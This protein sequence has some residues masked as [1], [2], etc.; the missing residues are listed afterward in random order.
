[1]NIQSL[2][3]LLAAILI[4]V[5]GWSV[6]L[7]DR[8][9]RQ[10]VTFT[11]LCFN[12]CFWYL[13]RFFVTTITSDVL[14]WAG[15]LFA[16]AIPTSAERFFRAFLAD[17]P[18]RPHPMSRPVIVSTTIFYL[19]LFVSLFYPVYRSRFFTLPLLFF[20]F[21]SLYHCVYLIYQRQRSIASRPEATRLTYLLYGGATTI[22]LAALDFVPHASLIF[23]TLGNVLTVVFM[24]FLSQTLFHYRLLDIKELLGKMVTLS[25]L[26]LILTVIYGLLLAWVGRDQPGVFFF[27]TVVASFVILVL[28]EQLRTRVEDRVNRWL[29]AEKYAFS[30]RLRVLTQDLANIIEARLAAARILAELEHS[31]RV[32]HVSI[33]L[34]D[35]AGASYRLAG[36]VGPQPVDVLDGT[37]RRLFL[38]RLR[39]SGLV[40]IEGLER[41]L[42]VQTAEN[43]EDAVVAVR[44]LLATMEDLF[45][46]VC[47]PLVSDKQ[48]LGILCLRDD[49]LREAYGTDELE[50]LR[51]VAA[52]AAITLRN[53]QVYEQM[54]ER[55]RLAALGQMAA[56]LAHEIRNPLGAI[57]GAA[58]LLK[59]DAP[60]DGQS[61]EKSAELGEYVEIIVEE[62]NRLDRVVSQ[63]LGYA[64]PDRGERQPLAINDVVFKTVQLLRSQAG[65]VE[66]Q[67]ELA[68]ELPEVRADPEQLRQVFLNLGINGIQAMD[69]KGTLRVETRLRRG[70]KRGAA[71][72]FVEVIFKDQGV[73]IPPETLSDIFIPFYTTKDGGTGLGLPICQRIVENH[74][75]T[76]EVRSEPGRGSSFT[77]V[78][79]AAEEPTGSVEVGEL[80][81][82]LDVERKAAR[83]P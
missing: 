7:R 76:I 14:V 53:S 43:Q 21:G 19:V 9:H 13:S 37:T 49:R 3:A 51:S 83:N 28:F 12:L 79:P 34:A 72:R 8:R 38:E 26:V 29:F 16:V 78:L 70:F 31:G 60:P 50:L 57:K 47:I 66:L 41:E 20:V 68:P 63:F 36:H 24:Y 77:V 61:A 44:N 5:I 35:S 71:A 62:V 2:S 32:T 46:A 48:L 56:G 22:S 74:K 58:Q 18:R 45:A 64:R 15:Q 40:T 59:S 81:R 25:T 65:E 39:Q 17:D 55:D 30:R 1:M 10:Y 52:Q 54:K 23:P 11:I 82:E 75:G 6:I 42:A 69:G 73:G 27:N 67:T 33:Y 4:F 80:R